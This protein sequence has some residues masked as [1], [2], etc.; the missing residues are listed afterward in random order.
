[1]RI[2]GGWFRVVLFPDLVIGGPGPDPAAGNMEK[3][4]R[5]QSNDAAVSRIIKLQILLLLPDD[6]KI[7]PR[8]RRFQDIYIIYRQ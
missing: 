1:V 4:G 6:F 8:I 5:H 3:V 7:S 2:T